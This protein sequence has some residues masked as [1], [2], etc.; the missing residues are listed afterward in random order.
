MNFKM[1]GTISLEGIQYA[2]VANNG[3]VYKLGVTATLA[4][5]GNVPN[6]LVSRIFSNE[7]V[8]EGINMLKTTYAT[9]HYVSINGPYIIHWLQTPADIVVTE[10]TVLS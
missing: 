3:S 2:I 9:P 7:V 8:E 1:L 10:S 6:F 4:G 5:A